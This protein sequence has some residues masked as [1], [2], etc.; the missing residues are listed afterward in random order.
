MSFES[1]RSRGRAATL[2][3]IILPIIISI[4]SVVL[5]FFQV[6]PSNIYL[7][8]LLS[9]L[10][11]AGYILFLA[12]MNGLAKYYEDPAIF[13]NSLYA[14]IATIVGAIVFITYLTHTL[15]FE[16]IGLLGALWALVIP[17]TVFIAGFIQENRCSC[18]QFPRVQNRRNQATL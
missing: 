8:I 9:F 12:A 1:S 14:F 6:S 3:I 5:V 18:V 17:I 4:I 15:G 13:R 7:S 2:L 16:W 10:G 11:Y